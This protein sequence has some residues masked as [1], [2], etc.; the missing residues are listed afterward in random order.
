MMS[1][2]KYQEAISSITFTMHL[3]VKPKALG[4][5][6]DENLDLLQELVDK[7]T[8]KK[9]T[10]SVCPNCDSWDIYSEEFDNKYNFCPNCGQ[11]IDWS[12]N[13]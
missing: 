3:R 12:E 11:A 1:K 13:E 7:A 6:E 5:C 10:K 8:P 4:H 9:P 2:K